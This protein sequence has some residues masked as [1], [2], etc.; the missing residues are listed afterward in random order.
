MFVNAADNNPLL[1]LLIHCSDCV[2]ME[3]DSQTYG[4]LRGVR[5]SLKEDRSPCLFGNRS[6]LLGSLPL[7][8]CLQLQSDF[9]ILRSFC[10]AMQH[11]GFR[12]VW[13]QGQRASQLRWIFL[14]KL[15]ANLRAFT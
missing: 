15:Q 8:P 6:I 9:D 5:S 1:S 11:F 12:G 14:E 3:P 7:Q 13:L 10:A 2:L 4:A